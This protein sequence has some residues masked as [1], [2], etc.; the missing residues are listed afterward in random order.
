MTTNNK[1]RR[2]RLQNAALQDSAE[3]SRRSGALCYLLLFE[4]RCPR[5]TASALQ[6]AEESHEHHHATEKIPSPEG[7]PHP[8]QTH[9][10]A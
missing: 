4:A 8:Q 3:V 9:E 6:L 7:F 5:A 10:K 2:A 1:T